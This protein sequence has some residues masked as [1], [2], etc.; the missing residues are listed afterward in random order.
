MLEFNN[1]AAGRRG[2]DATACLL[3]RVLRRAA[4]LSW[5]SARIPPNLV[6]SPIR[7]VQPR[8]G[9]ALSIAFIVIICSPAGRWSVRGRLAKHGAVDPSPGQRLVWATVRRA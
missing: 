2:A 7:R 1:G 3:Q 4:G 5:Q 9:V 8:S 6:G